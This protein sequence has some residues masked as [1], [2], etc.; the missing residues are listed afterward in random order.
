[1]KR[2]LRATEILAWTAFFAFAA[3]V[4]A[5]R[6]WVL[7]DIERYRE[8]IVAAMSRGIGLP[9]RVGR[10]EAGW[11]GLRPQITLSD[12]RIHDA[13]G[14][15]ALVLP[16]VH[17]VIAWRSLLHGGLR[18]HQLAIDGL[19]L[20]VRRDAAGD[21][22]VAGTRLARGGSG[23]GPGFGGWLLGQGEIVVRN[24][25]IEWH[26]EMRGA[27]PLA[28]SALDLRLLGSGTS[29]SLGLTARPP[30]ELGTSLEVRAL[31]Y[32]D[33]LQ[34]AGW[35]G[36]V[37]AQVG[38]TDLAAW[39]AWVDYPFNIRHGQGAL[40]VWSSV[41]QGEV[42]AVTADLA[43]SDVW[44]ALADEL[45]PLEL[46]SLQGRVYA[47]VLADGVELSGQRLAMVM[48]RGPEVPQTDFQI[49]WRPQAGGTLGASVIDLEAIAH[50][51]ESLPLPPQLSG[52][53]AE[54]APRGRLAEARFE[55]SGP[56]DA[57]TGFTA[58]ARFSDLA[59]R[60][61]DDIPGFSGLSGRLEATKDRGKLHLDSRQV[62]L[63]LPLVFPQ[64]RL[65]FGS[66]SGE[67]GWER[68]AGGALSVRVGSLTFSNADFSGNLFGSYVHRGE[69]PGTLDLSAIFNRADGS[70][71]G[72]YLPHVLDEE[73]RRWLANAVVAGE[74]SN[75]QVRVRGDLRDFPFVDPA[76]GQFL[77]TARIEKGVLDY[78]EGWPRI[79]DIDGELSFE[80]DRMEV[81]ARSGSIL[82]ARLSGVRVSLP[83]FRG[84]DKRVL[85]SGQADG[86][87]AEFLKYI[88]SSPLRETAG[89]FVA[90]M[91]AAGRGKLRLKLELPLAD[92]EKTKVAGEYEFADNRIKVIDELPPIEQAAGRL[93]F[94]DAGFTLQEVRGRLLGGGLPAVG[95][96]H[97]RRCVGV[98]VR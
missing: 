77:V 81:V 57:L 62:Q 59:M 73:P 72:R 93:A 35:H 96:T 76:R 66:L 33:G 45:S 32:A 23:G 30:A 37:F 34:G 70:A 10:I 95:G 9:V 53:L 49:V 43:L 80:R 27:P 6:Y 69:G 7:P 11:L 19:R 67:L 63:E 21:L 86:P 40:R 3:L 60:P 56:F 82:G 51:V 22:Y 44:I 41:E 47:R 97:P 31:I 88:A 94:T 42:K 5:L 78:A 50:L 36:R 15:E 16:S 98:T 64:P 20:G 39:R 85:V 48:A 54:R 65:G 29:L 12:V 8:H 90:A 74:G 61:R 79:E 68:E 46:A 91:Q 18:L 4:L 55:W 26:D 38:Y 89:S 75:V 13:Q 25:E 17:N 92:L 2:L 87:T 28:L 52:M 24:A 83:S 58:R 1:M 84:A 71:L 14:R